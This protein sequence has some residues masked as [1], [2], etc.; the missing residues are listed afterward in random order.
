MCATQV[1]ENVLRNDAGVS[2]ESDLDNATYLRRAL[3]LAGGQI[4]LVGFSFLL[5]ALY[6][7]IAPTLSCHPQA[8]R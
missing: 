3:Q 5:L 6:C 7:V 4:K 2:A 8:V 1:G